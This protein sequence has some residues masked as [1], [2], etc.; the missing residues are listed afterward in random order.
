MI[1][2]GHLS[3]IAVLPFAAYACLAAA[4]GALR[5]RPDWVR[6]AERAVLAVFALLLLALV[7]LEWALLTDRFDLGFVARVS[8]VEQPWPF[9]M[10]LW[11]GQ[12]GSL[13]LWALVLGG[14]SAL[15]VWQNRE[16]N[17]ALMPW[18]VV[19]LM[20]NLLFFAVV[21]SS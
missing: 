1:E 18:V 8:S 16:R 17:R 12:E 10:A 6:S 14:L 3:L 13:L 20:A 4:A 9:K 2:L 19:S 21:V 5:A 7:G 11:G 15:V